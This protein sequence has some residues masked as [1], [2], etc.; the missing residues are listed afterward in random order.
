MSA[1]KPI[2]RGE[3]E[4]GAALRAFWRSIGPEQGWLLRA[5]AL[6][7]VR[8][9]AALGP[10][11]V[12]GAMA[13]RI[14]GA[15]LD[16]AFVW[17]ASG[18][19]AASVVV[20]FLTHWISS[21]MLLGVARD[22]TSRVRLELLRKV[23]SAPVG[24]VLSRP[25]G[26]VTSIIDRDV[27]DLEDFLVASVGGLTSNAAAAPVLVAIVAFLD[28]V[29]GAVLLFLGWLT[30][31]GYVYKL[32]M[33]SR[34][35]AHRYRL[36]AA[37]DERVVEFVQGI[38]VAKAF[39]LRS[40]LAERLDASLRDYKAENLRSVRTTIPVGAG[41]GAAASLMGGLL[42]AVAGWRYSEGAIDASATGA[43]LILIAGATLAFIRFG[44]ASGSVVYVSAAVTRIAGLLDLRP[45]PVA[46]RGPD[47]SGYGVCFEGVE[48]EY[49]PGTPVLHGV[50]FVAPAGSVTAVV[51]ES[52]AGKST[53]LH[54]L[55][56]LWKPDSGRI[57]IGGVDLAALGRGQRDGLMAFVL[58]DTYFPDA[59]FREAIAGDRSVED[60]RIVAA[61]TT[62]Q[63][64]DFIQERESGL[65]ARVGEGGRQL[66][67]GERQR[68]AIARALVAD[69]PIVCLDEATAAL[70]ATTE[71]QLREATASL[72]EG[73]TVILV[74]HRPATIRGA[75]TIVVLEDG[76]V[77]ESGTH[78]ELMAMR[79]VYA[80]RSQALEDA[81]RRG[82]S[83]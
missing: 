63:C 59:T 49:E 76:V 48:F 35:V 69:T 33:Q 61:A 18:V 54:L 17:S 42:L 21:K 74:A 78:Q 32:R 26:E 77:V 83:R 19:L 13:G 73:R 79:G 5:L 37:Q 2:R 53:L 22:V 39:G 30:V 46:P 3:L 43:L 29:V 70:D 71:R 8:G 12:V 23:R 55:A 20:A 11:L 75:D 60:E 65:D 41:L 82:F 31:M 40:E 34:H 44:S 10:L 16:G 56:G 66:S 45:A 7:C 15:G 24:D 57:L 50:D 6:R 81:G 72:L 47:P 52:G 62:A 27:S 9:I 68:L 67:G 64:W 51:G 14:V 1:G 58:Q 80:M 25:R 36:R 38:E 28:P 4:F